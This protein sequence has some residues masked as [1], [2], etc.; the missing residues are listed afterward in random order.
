MITNTQ[1]RPYRYPYPQTQRTQTLFS[2]DW[3]RYFI[4]NSQQKLTLIA[5]AAC[6]LCIGMVSALTFH[7]KAVTI[8]ASVQQVQSQSATLDTE[9][10]TLLTERARLSSRE[11]I[12]KVAAKLQLFEPTADQ[13]QHM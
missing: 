13:V 1:I 7:T 5:L 6:A 4:L 3:S 10:I 12:G 8:Q 11:R 9:H 2:G